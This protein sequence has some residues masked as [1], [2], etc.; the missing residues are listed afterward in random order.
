MEFEFE[1]AFD[2][3][4]RSSRIEFAFLQPALHGAIDVLSHSN[5]SPALRYR[6]RGHVPVT[7]IVGCL[8]C[9]VDVPYLRWSCEIV[10]CAL[11]FIQVPFAGT[12]GLCTLHRTGVLERQRYVC[13]RSTRACTLLAIATDPFSP[14]VSVLMGDHDR[15]SPREDNSPSRST[16][17]LERRNPSRADLP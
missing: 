16:C 14:C 2:R 8:Q 5:S 4:L 15:G 10:S 17:S 11:A 12:D 6:Y 1:F 7:W 3:T 9:K 13:T